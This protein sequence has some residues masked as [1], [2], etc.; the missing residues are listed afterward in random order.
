MAEGQDS[1]QSPL[2]V[3][4]W[5]PLPPPLGGVSRWTLRFREAAPRHGL[6]VRVIDVAP[7]VDT[8]DERSRFDWGRLPVA[9]R[10]LRELRRVLR[11][12]RPDVAHVTSSLFW[13][14]P[15]DALALLLCRRAGVPVVLNL[16]SSSQIVAWREGLGG[17]RRRALDRSLRLADAVVVLSRELETYLSRTLPGLRVERIGNMVDDAERAP[18]PGAPVLPPRRAACRVLFVGFRMPLKGL[19][20]LAEAVLA[21]PG[22]ELVVVGGPGGGA[23]DAEADRR[24]EQA[25]GRLREAGRLLETGALP[26]EQVARI[27]HEADVFALPTHREGF[28]NTLLEAMAAGLPC[29]ACP[30]GAVPEMLEDGCG[31]SVPVGDALAL[32]E[33]LRRL[34]ADPERCALLGRRARARVAERYSAAAV[35]ARYRALYETLL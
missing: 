35:M 23:L 2:R 7:P 31:E 11:E 14:T 13:A 22:C 20:E 32:R 19:G 18:A 9:T 33:S 25:L 3:A 27:Y 28:P 17:L 15:R 34:A 12:E 16:R 1:V 29:V 6:R 8:V 4:L 21:L 30:V 24:M 26:P 5:A 10:A